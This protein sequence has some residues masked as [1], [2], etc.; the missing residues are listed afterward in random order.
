MFI[1]ERRISHKIT[2]DEWES[3]TVFKEALENTTVKD[4]LD[5]YESYG[6]CDMK[7]VN[8]TLIKSEQ[9]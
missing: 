9:K 4:L 3:Q 1:I 8:I 5:W 6:M 2:H 7:D